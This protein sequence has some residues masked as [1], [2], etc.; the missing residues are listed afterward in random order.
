[1]SVSG[2]QSSAPSPVVWGRECEIHD[3]GYFT[4]P[5][6]KSFQNHALFL[7]TIEEI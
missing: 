3:T 4:G 7:P 1:M 5:N 2:L 6:S